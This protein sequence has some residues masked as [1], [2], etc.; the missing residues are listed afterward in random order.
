VTWKD[1]GRDPIMFEEQYNIS[2]GWTY[3]LGHNGGPIGKGYWGIKW[4]HDP[5]HHV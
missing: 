5:W 4:S 2:N 3:T 1:Q